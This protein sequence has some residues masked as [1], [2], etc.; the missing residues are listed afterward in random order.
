MTPGQNEYPDYHL[1]DAHWRTRGLQEID[2]ISS[3]V[4]QVCGNQ[5]MLSLGFSTMPLVQGLLNNGV[6]VV[7]VDSSERLVLEANR[8]LPG[9]YI[10]GSALGLPYYANSFQTILCTDILEQLP[11]HEIPKAIAEMHRVVRRFLYLKLSTAFEPAHPWRQTIHDRVWWDARFFGAGFRRHPISMTVLPYAS[12]ENEGPLITLIYEK[13]PDSANRQYPMSALKAERDLHMDMLRESGRRSDAHM[14]RYTL[15]LNYIRPNDTVLDAACGLGYGTAILSD[16]SLAAIVAGIAESA[17]AETYAGIC[18]GEERSNIKFVRGDVADLGAIADKSVDVVVSFETIAHL[19]NPEM[20]LK[21]AQRILTPGGRFICSVPNQFFDEAGCDRQVFDLEKITAICSQYYLIE[22]VFAQTA[23]GGMKLK[24]SP[25]RITEIIPGH[26]L[27]EAEWWILICMKDPLSGSK[28]DYR[29]SIYPS[30]AESVSNV[31]AFGRDY[32]NPWLVRSLI[33]MD[34]R[35]SSPETLGIL[36]ERVLGQVPP[37]SADEGA[38]LCVLA[39]QAIETAFPDNVKTADLIARLTAYT[40]GQAKNAHEYRWIISNQYALAKLL[41][42]RGLLN[43]ARQAFWEC[44]QMDCTRFSPLL[45][46]KTLDAAF[47]AGWL[48]A[49]QGLNSDAIQCWNYGL[50]EAKRILECPWDNVLVDLQSPI[51]FGMRELTQV[52]DAATRCANG[53]HFIS[54]QSGIQ[55]ALIPQIFYSLQRTAGQLRSHCTNLEAGIE[56]LKNQIASLTPASQPHMK[57]NQWLLIPHLSQSKQLMGVSDQVAVW[58]ANL[59]GYWSKAIYMCPPAKI[60]F[61]I[62]AGE[63]GEFLSAAAIHPDA[64]DKPNAGGCEFILR[65]DDGLRLSLQID[66]IQSAGDRRW[67]EF[68]ISIPANAAGCHRIT[69]ETRSPDGRNDFRWALWRAPEF[70]W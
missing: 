48:A 50:L 38:A 2:A 37:H 39:Y 29:E 26:E 12:L 5:R 70:V 9:R 11:E 46:T 18:F 52:L 24:N 67:H 27:P 43:A 30:P 65:A 15:A 61:M 66:P 60:E 40:E 13:I 31:T 63:A 28:S 69:L 56:Y 53:L 36:A 59:G 22:K 55:P 23:G 64:W 49:G 33:S 68:V 34:M 32:E 42:K 35:W 25:R 21:E 14:A 62:P 47:W 58:E 17:F 16:G 51:L 6:D 44:A 45:A 57:S 41:Q 7:G 19:K 8:F 4:L 54:R 20:F 1:K 10:C 3:Q